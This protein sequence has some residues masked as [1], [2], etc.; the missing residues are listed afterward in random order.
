DM[1]SMT[2]GRACYSMEPSHYAKVPK[3]VAEDVIAARGGGK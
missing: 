3:N 2:Q 1:R